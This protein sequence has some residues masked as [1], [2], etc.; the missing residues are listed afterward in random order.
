MTSTITA[1]VTI[2]VAGHYRLDPERTTITFG[3]RHLFGLG[4]VRGGFRLREG[5]I[6]VRD[7]LEASSATATISAASFQTGTMGRDV[8]VRS[9]RFLDAEHH[10]GITFTST[11]LDRDDVGWVLRGALTVRGTTRPLDVRVEQLRQDGTRL[12]LTATASVDRY[13]FG[14]T[15]LRGLAGRRLRLTLDVTADKAAAPA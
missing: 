8:S 13:A 2:P 6:R 12:R 7:P 5:T 15:A 10:P 1:S 3:T 11:G 14:I 4:A 9:P